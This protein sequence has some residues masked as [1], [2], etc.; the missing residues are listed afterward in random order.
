[1][2]KKKEARAEDEKL[3]KLEQERLRKVIEAQRKE[4]EEK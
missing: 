3:K 1:M 4:D 2:N